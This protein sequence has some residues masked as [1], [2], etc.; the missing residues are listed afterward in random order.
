M[1]TKALVSQKKKKKDEAKR[2]TE[3]RWIVKGSI[4]Y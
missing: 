1:F 2:N 4:F 3:G